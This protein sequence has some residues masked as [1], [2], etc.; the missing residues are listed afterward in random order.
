MTAGY[1]VRLSSAPD[2]NVSVSSQPHQATGCLTQI[3]Y[4]YLWQRNSVTKC[5]I[6]L[7]QTSWQIILYS[8][9]QINHQLPTR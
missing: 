4:I 1:E 5:K 6:Q 8:E 7:N 2:A 9:M 3:E